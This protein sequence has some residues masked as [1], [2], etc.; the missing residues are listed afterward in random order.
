MSHPHERA[1]APQQFQRTTSIDFPAAS[2]IAAVYPH[3][4]LADAWA[5]RLPPDATADPERLASHLFAT[6]PTWVAVLMR[7][8]DAIV[9][10]F[11]LKTSW[12]LLS[13][14]TPSTTPRIGLFRIYSRHP[15]EIVLGEDDRHLD[16][17]LSVLRTVAASASGAS[18]VVATTVQ[19]HNLLGRTYIGIVAP[20][21]RVIVRAT[22]RRAA[23]RGWPADDAAC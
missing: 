11:G 21:H 18:L 15:D 2:R 14:N 10:A 5:I 8:R 4:D 3:P 12:S 6:S 17:R 9:M 7:I 22:L 23:R 1:I 20:F 16:F 13:A 19:C